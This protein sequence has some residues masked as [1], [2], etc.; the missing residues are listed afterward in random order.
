MSPTVGR[1]MTRDRFFLIKK[2]IY[3]NDLREGRGG[4][5]SLRKLRRVFESISEAS[6]KLWLPRAKLVIDG[7]MVSYAGDHAGAVY[8]PRKPIKN[9]FKIYVLAD[10]T[11][12][13]IKFFP[14]F[15]RDNDNVLSIVSDLLGENFLHKGF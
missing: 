5:D 7:S 13:A 6:R 15:D 10:Y 4:T 14:A 8:M 11:G 1:V 12:Y 9:G 2:F 3:F